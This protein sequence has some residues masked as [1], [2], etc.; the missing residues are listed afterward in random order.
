M[1]ELESCPTDRG[2]TNSDIIGCGS[3]NVTWDE[4]EGVFEC[5]DCGMWWEPE[6]QGREKARSV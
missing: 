6:R 3:S 5:S 2:P 4:E 1:I